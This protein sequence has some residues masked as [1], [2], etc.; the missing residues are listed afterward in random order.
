M[1]KV[2][3]TV[4]K[5]RQDLALVILLFP[6]LLGYTSLGMPSLSAR[7][8]LEARRYGFRMQF[9]RLWVSLQWIFFETQ[10]T[11]WVF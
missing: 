5:N 8:K 2:T 7:E 6:F 11:L 1:H 4:L 10:H 3:S 9:C